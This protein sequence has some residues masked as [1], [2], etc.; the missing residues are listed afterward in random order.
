MFP[1][2]KDFEWSIMDS[3]YE[4]LDEWKE[5]HIRKYSMKNRKLSTK[6]RR[7]AWEIN[8]ITIIMKGRALWEIVVMRIITKGG[9]TRR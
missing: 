6:V 4:D 9:L 5:D 3:V 8:V 2:R 1:Q 7:V